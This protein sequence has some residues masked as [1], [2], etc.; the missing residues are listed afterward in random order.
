MSSVD[1]FI[2]IVLA[3][4]V[5]NGL[6]KGF[7][8]E[9]FGLLGILF[10]IIIA[11]VG[12]DPLSQFLRIKFPDIPY[13]LFPI[14]SFI[15]IFLAVIFLSRFLANSLSTL[16][17]TI[18]LGWLNRLLGAVFGG[19]KGAIILSILFVILDYIPS[20]G[21]YRSMES[22]SRLVAPI[23]DVAPASYALIIS[24]DINTT[25]I[26]QK[27]NKI[28]QRGRQTIQKEIYKKLLKDSNVDTSSN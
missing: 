20:L 3:F 17:E 14:I 2:A 6:R 28:F 19:L 8:K 1:V 26:E 11:L 24:Q 23:H 5:L 27:L 7:F 13:L 4:F 10:G 18:H 22:K 16:S 25:R 12:T 15:V 9:V 21:L